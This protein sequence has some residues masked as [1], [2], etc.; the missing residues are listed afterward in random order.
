MLSKQVKA[1]IR[2]NRVRHVMFESRRE[3]AK[4]AET[5]RLWRANGFQLGLLDYP[6]VYVQGVQ[7]AEQESQGTHTS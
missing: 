2:K 4:Y 3:R 5:M 6:S 1:R 7:D